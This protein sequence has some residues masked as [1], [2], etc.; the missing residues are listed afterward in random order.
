[1]NPDLILYAEPSTWMP[2]VSSFLL[3]QLRRGALARWR[4]RRLD[5][6]YADDSEWLLILGA[7]LTVPYDCVEGELNCTLK[8][9]RILGFHACRPKNLD[10]YFSRGIMAPD[11]PALIELLEDAIEE[12]EIPS[13]RSELLATGRSRLKEHTDSVVYFVL[14]QRDLLRRAGHYLIYGSEWLCSV[15][16][17]RQPLLRNR[18]VP[19]LME[20]AF[21]LAEASGG[22]RQQLARLLLHEWTRLTGLNLDAPRLVDFSF[23]VQGGIPSASI[24]GHSHPSAIRDPLDGFRE[25]VHE[26][27]TCSHCGPL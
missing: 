24:V 20:I 2:L 11:A 19:T 7:G 9:R 23:A 18:G 21:P 13:L 10:G 27:T 3:P 8:T 4:K 16:G 17:P 12:L 6:L 14:D 5:R 26:R 22:D 15:F 1:V 25:Y